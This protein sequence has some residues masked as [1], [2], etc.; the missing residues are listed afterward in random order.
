MSRVAP[1]WVLAIFVLTSPIVS[2]S[3][4]GPSSDATNAIET[5]WRAYQNGQLAAALAAYTNAAR[6]HPDDA[7]LWY[8]LGCLQALTADPT[9]AHA[10]LERALSLNPQHAAAHDALGQLLEQSGDRDAALAR[11]LTARNL[12]P[13]NPKFLRHAARLLLQMNRTTEARPLLVELAGLTPR[14]AET[15]HQLGILAL[16]A[17]EPD[18][19]IHEFQR[20]VEED[21]HLVMAWNG[22]ALAHSRVGSFPEAAYA[23][24]QA[25]RLAPEDANT[26]TNVGVLAARERRWDEARRAWQ[27]VLAQ[28]PGFE[29]AAKNLET[30]RTASAPVAP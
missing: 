14:D 5:G 22:L 28:H 26:Q 2:A 11:Y 8:D 10:A 3:T 4:A 25:M 6:T 23:L 27:Q 12:E 21:P 15:H 7:S 1:G 18:L 29:P 19:A 9:G 16:R 13:Y 17:N 20:A 24:E 30:L